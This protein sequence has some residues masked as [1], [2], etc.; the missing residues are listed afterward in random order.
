MKVIFLDIDGVL[1]CQSSK[2][3][4]GVYV[5][6]DADKV[7]RLR[8]IVD[9]TGAKIVLSSSWRTEWFKDEDFNTE[10]GKYID[11]KLKRERLAILDKT[12]TDRFDRRRKEVEAWLEGKDIEA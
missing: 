1:N 10:T 5:G 2:S 8:E 6:I 11:R 4:C 9:E 7:A 12:I 3:R